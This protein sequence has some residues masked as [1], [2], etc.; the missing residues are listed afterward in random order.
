MHADRWYVEIPPVTR[1]YI[2]L[3]CLLSLCTTLGLVSEHLLYLNWARV[4]E[5]EWW[6]L[7]TNFAYF[8][9]LSADFFFQVFWLYTDSRGL[10]EQWYHRRT[11]RYMTVLG[12][13]ALGLLPA[14]G[15][16]RLDFLSHSMAS[17]VLYLWARRF[18]DT[19]IG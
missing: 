9:V 11:R 18:P 5:G 12:L 3:C 7:L 1:A 16:L 8:D 2:T 13:T 15:W 6:R 14:A 10:E 19:H 4:R 17:A